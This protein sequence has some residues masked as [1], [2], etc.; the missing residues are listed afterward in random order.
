[1]WHGLKK[2]T[3]SSLYLFIKRRDNNETK[4]MS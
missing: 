3:F 4:T 2:E 1:M